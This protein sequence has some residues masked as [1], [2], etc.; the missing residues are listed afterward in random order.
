MSDKLKERKVSLC[1]LVVE[2][3]DSP[4]RHLAGPMG[5][6]V[7]TRDFEC[8]GILTCFG[9][10]IEIEKGE[11]STEGTFTPVAGGHL[12]KAWRLVWLSGRRG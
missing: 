6:D 1:A 12:P 9:K 7:T 2:A 10:G 3:C 8:G 11:S 4:T 5:R